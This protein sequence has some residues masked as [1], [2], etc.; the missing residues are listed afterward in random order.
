[1]YLNFFKDVGSPF[2]ARQTLYIFFLEISKNFRQYLNFDTPR[3]SIKKR[4][5][6]IDDLPWESIG[7]VECERIGLTLG[8]YTSSYIENLAPTSWYGS[9]NKLLDVLHISSDILLLATS[10]KILRYKLVVGIHYIKP[11]IINHPWGSIWSIF[12]LTSHS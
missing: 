10:F 7:K 9:I 8:A 11:C 2:L 4:G 5:I 12:W 1:M 6:L 3:K